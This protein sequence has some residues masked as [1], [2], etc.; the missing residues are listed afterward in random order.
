MDEAETLFPGMYNVTFDLPSQSTWN[1]N[2]N[3][4]ENWFLF[5]W[6]TKHIIWEREKMNEIWR[7]GWGEGYREREKHTHT[8][9]R[10]HSQFWGSFLEQGTHFIISCWKLSPLVATHSQHS[11]LNLCI[12]DMYSQKLGKSA[13][14]ITQNG[15]AAGTEAIEISYW[16]RV[17]KVLPLG[18]VMFVSWG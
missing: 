6:P 10:V 13:S 5:L 17:I 18:S 12:P 14:H 3:L 8:H 1:T 7:D 11:D 4:I 16:S 9:T 15:L 2:R